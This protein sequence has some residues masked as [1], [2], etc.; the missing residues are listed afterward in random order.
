MYA[1]NKAFEDNNADEP[2]STPDISHGGDHNMPQSLRARLLVLIIVIV[3]VPVFL[4]GYFL[5]VTAEKALIAEKERK[6]FGAAVFL[7]KALEGSYHDILKKYDAVSYPKS[8]QVNILNLELRDITDRVAESYPGIGV[9]YYSKELDAILTYGPSNTYGDTV[10]RSIG[11]DHQGRIVM[12]TGLPRVQEGFLVRG[13]IM[14][15]MHPVIRDGQVIGYIWANE[16]TADIRE[17][18]GSMNSKIFFL[19]LAGLV[20][21]IIGVARVIDRVAADVERVKDGLIRSSEKFPHFLPDMPGE[22]GEIASAINDMIRDLDEKKKLEQQVQHTERLAAAGEIAASLAHEI[23]NP[24]MAIKGFAQLLKEANDPSET[25]EYSSIIIKETDRMNRLIEQLLC[26][27]RPASSLLEPV[28]VNSVLDNTL[29]LIESRARRNNIEI[30][31]G[32]CRCLPPVI[33]DCENLKQVLLNIMIN[34]IQAMDNGGILTAA[35]VYKTEEKLIVV[36]ISDTGVGIQPELIEKLFDPFFT[37]KE[38]GTGLGLAV[39]QRFVHDWGGKISVDSTVG[40]GSIFTVC[41]PEAGGEP[42]ES[43]STGC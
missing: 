25:E 42:R 15:A 3:A 10:G 38:N 12:D 14:N 37:T 32:Y 19:V 24:L 7:D 41:L 8:V 29:M 40:S 16:M 22:I 1:S 5:I 28:D 13:L 2:L 18:I 35:T 31:R 39:A 27:A 36:S 23:R 30:Q 26:L 11:S 21:G 17:Q 33:A 20:V 9:G 43:E 34:A 6:L 4:A